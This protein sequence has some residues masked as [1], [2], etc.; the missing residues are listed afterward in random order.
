M[1]LDVFGAWSLCDEALAGGGVKETEGREE[2]EGIW[3]MKA[4]EEE[5]EEEECPFRLRIAETSL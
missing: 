5:E 1:L 3:L 2:A 4:D